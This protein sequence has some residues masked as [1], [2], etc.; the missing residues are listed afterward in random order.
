MQI[1]L[2][3]L[4]HNTEVEEDI[5]VVMSSGSVLFLVGEAVLDFR[6]ILSSDGLLGED[7]FVG[8]KCVG[9]SLLITEVGEGIEEVMS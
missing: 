4:F 9:E 1:R 3:S 2:I 8:D 5:E 6:D 7:G